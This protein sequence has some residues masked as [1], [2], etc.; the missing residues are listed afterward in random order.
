VSVT[1]TAPT[2]AVTAAGRW[3]LVTACAMTVAGAL[4]L[5]AALDHLHHD[6]IFVVFFLLVGVAQAST[7]LGLYGGVRPRSA[8]AM[9]AGT[10]ALILLYGYS[11]T[12]GLRIGPHADRAESPDALGLTVVA[13][14]LLVVAGLAAMLPGAWRG[15]AVNA[16]LAVGTGVW[17]LWLTGTLR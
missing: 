16:L 6:V 3:P 7:G 10:V 4:H 14:E 2:P 9:M 1:G 5:I 11:R 15:R 13:C 12:V 8:V 17:V